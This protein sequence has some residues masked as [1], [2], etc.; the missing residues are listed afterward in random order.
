MYSGSHRKI[1]S[2]S[3]LSGLTLPSNNCNKS[4]AGLPLLES[5]DSV[6]VESVG[7]EIDSMC[8]TSHLTCLPGGG[9]PVVST[10]IMV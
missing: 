2:L 10:G 3:R 4:G 6:G 1:G 7:K 8:P 5:L 9:H